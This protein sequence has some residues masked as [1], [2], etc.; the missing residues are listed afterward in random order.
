MTFLRKAYRF[1][2]QALSL[3]IW[4]ASMI[5]ILLILLLA[6]TVNNAREKEL[7][8]LFSRQQLASAQNAAT[9][10][11]EILSQAE[12]NIALLTFFDPDGKKLTKSHY[13]E[14][15]ALYA[16]WGKT[17]DA[18]WVYDIH[19]NI[20]RI[21]PQEGRA[22]VDLTGHFHA[23]KRIQRQYLNIVA[24]DRLSAEDIGQASQRY[25][26]WGYPV[27]RDNNIF[28]GAWMVSFS[29]AA[30]MD[31]CEKQIKDNQ[32]G[33]MWLVNE[34]GR[35]LLH[36]NAS[37]IGKHI[38]D[39]AQD[40]RGSSI[41]FP[42]ENGRHLNARIL[43]ENNK[44]QKSVI[45]YAPLPIAGNTWYVVVTAPY[46][47]VIAPVRTTFLYTTFSALILIMVLVIVGIYYAFREGKR[48][49]MREEQHRLKEREAW[50]ERL[51]R[52]KKT[53]DGIIEGS[54]IPIFV[55]NRDHQVILWNRAC[56]ELTGHSADAMVGTDRHYIP[57]YSV[58][59]PM[60]ADLIVDSDVEGLGKYY[61]AKNVKK[62]EKVIGAYEA[63]DYYENLGG[64]ESLS[65]FSG[66][67]D[68]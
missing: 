7:A 51:L 66:G 13:R 52:E 4:L 61:G 16:I 57:F 18:V 47:L 36:P 28:A 25:L 50:Q 5:V 44:R 26:V 60:I 33:D 56:V 34:Q 35:I 21:V 53:I 3:R 14:L 20:R 2:H 32:L 29:L 55:I 43:L 68:L 1:L 31:A 12:R 39:L 45:A 40:H 38:V 63:T 24:T 22:A 8:D 27:W 9:R 64:A 48:L 11:T 58:K 65:L 37:F 62:S 41:L 19:D 42:S 23:L 67:S 10:L 46:S 6:L 49:R 15:D 54:P 30:L 17:I 59:R